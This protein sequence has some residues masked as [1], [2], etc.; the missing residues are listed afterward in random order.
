MISGL[1]FW[2]WGEHFLYWG[3]GQWHFVIG[4]LFR[5]QLKMMQSSALD[6]KGLSHLKM[7]PHPPYPTFSHFQFSELRCDSPMF[8]IIHMNT[9]IMGTFTMFAAESAI[10]CAHYISKFLLLIQADW[11]LH[12][13]K[14]HWKVLSS[15]F[16]LNYKE[17]VKLA[18]IIRLIG[19][20]NNKSV[21]KLHTPFTS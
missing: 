21:S 4:V 8:D 1:R 17:V 7:R 3:F 6:I 5:D 10:P 12:V 11:I 2:G 20:F 14:K 19:L 18:W 16:N 9:S 13:L 15:F